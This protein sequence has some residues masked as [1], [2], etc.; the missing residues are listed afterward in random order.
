MWWRKEKTG[1]AILWVQESIALK[2]R[3]RFAE[4]RKKLEDAVRVLRKAKDKSLLAGALSELSQVCF[5]LGD[6]K[7]T[8]KCISESANIRT[9][10]QDYRG[11]SIDYQ[12]IGTML[13]TANQLNQAHG[14]FSDSLGLATLVDDKTLIAAS[15]SNLGLVASLRGS[16][17]EAETH[18]EKSQG[19]RKQ[20]GDQLGIA[21]NLNHLGQIKEAMGKL[22][23]AEALFRESLSILRVLG[24]PEAAIA[25]DNLQKVQRRRT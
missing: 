4:A 21:K 14:F 8:L 24:A 17:S 23:E 19:I 25:L 1:K 22:D 15:E 18:F 13:M 2:Q 10:L 16:Y 5:R 11:L 9:E 3:G 7:Q 6:A 12:M 20:Q